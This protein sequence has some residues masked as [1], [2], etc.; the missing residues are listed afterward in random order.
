MNSVRTIEFLVCAWASFV[1]LLLHRGVASRSVAYT[2]LLC[3][4]SALV[5]G[6]VL[7]ARCGLENTAGGAVKGVRGL[8]VEM[9]RGEE[10]DR[11]TLGESE[12]EVWE[13]A[14]WGEDEDKVFELKMPESSVMMADIKGADLR[15][16]SG[17]SE[18]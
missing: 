17:L 8:A 15:T 5:F 2:S 16:T 7:N 6:G 4:L 18:C 13:S 12:G 10:G 9:E 11:E 1:S 3:G 14:E